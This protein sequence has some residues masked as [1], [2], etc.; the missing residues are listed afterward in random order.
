MLLPLKA[1]CDRKKMRKDGT[2][3]LIFLYRSSRHK[4][5]VEKEKMNILKQKNDIILQEKEIDL[6][7]AMMQG[8]E[9]ER[10]RIAK[11]LHDGIGGML[12]A[13]KMNLVVLKPE[14]TNDDIDAIV[15][16]VENTAIE[17]RRTSHNLMPEILTRHKLDQALIMY[18]ENMQIPSQLHVDLQFHGDLHK[19]SKQ[20]ELIIYRIIQELVQNIIKH[21]KATK[22]EIQITQ[23]ENNV[24]IVVEDNGIGFDS[25][26]QHKGLVLQ[27]LQFRVKALEGDIFIQSNK[28]N[29]TTIF[30]EFDLR[31]LQNT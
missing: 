2:T 8:E 19:L 30:I 16:I 4:Q 31:K 29:S 21:S 18:L 20:V 3:S 25:N 26:E 5:L 10:K 24:S 13:I 22:A 7:K 23:F 9:E 12:A 15:K 6:L 14:Q 17:V 27:N 11:E 28:G 1:I